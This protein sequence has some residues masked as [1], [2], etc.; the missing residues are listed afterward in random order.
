MP[1]KEETEVLIN[2]GFW[3]LDPEE[4]AR[5]TEDACEK[6]GVD[7]FHDLSAEE[8]DEAYSK[9]DTT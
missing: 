4:R 9:A 8:R 3:D 7:N 6:A 5:I 2:H 1:A